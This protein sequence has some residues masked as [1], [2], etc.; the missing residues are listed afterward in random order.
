M[1]P[2]HVS[3]QLIPAISIAP[4]VDLNL[5]LGG[6]IKISLLLYGAV[7]ATEEVF[8]ITSYRPITSAFTVFMVVLSAW[9]YHNAI[10][11]YSEL[12][13]S[14]VTAIYSLPFQIIIPF[15]ILIISI[16]KNQKRAGAKQSG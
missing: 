12:Q 11:W 7:K 5:I 6:G 8:N 15:L 10:E 2:N 14:I 1:F 13:R 9:V 4:L 16:Y 3:A